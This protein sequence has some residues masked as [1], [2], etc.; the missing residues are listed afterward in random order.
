MVSIGHIFVHKLV[1]TYAFVGNYSKGE[2]LHGRVLQTA[3][4]S[5]DSLKVKFGGDSRIPCKSRSLGGYI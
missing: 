1:H 5:S 4:S 2:S 3:I